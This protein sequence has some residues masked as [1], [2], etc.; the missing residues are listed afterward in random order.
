[1]ASGETETAGLDGPVFLVRNTAH[2][3]ASAAEASAPPRRRED[4]YET[5]DDAIAAYAAMPRQ[6]QLRVEYIKDQA[7]R[8]VLTRQDI[9][10][11]LKLSGG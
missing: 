10:H 11:R 1:M 7:G 9:E 4:R 6:D 3:G 8:H 2:L 5:L